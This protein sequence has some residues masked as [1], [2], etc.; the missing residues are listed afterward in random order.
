M[1]FGLKVDEVVNG[2]QRKMI[3]KIGAQYELMMW[4]MFIKKLVRTK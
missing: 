4:L 2:E 1:F 3:D